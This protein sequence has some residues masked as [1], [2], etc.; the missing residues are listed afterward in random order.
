MPVTGDAIVEVAVDAAELRAAPSAEGAVLETLSQ[1]DELYLGAASETVGETV[2]WPATNPEAGARGYIEETELAF[3]DFL[4][5]PTPVS[6]ED[7]VAAALEQ[8]VPIA[9]A[10]S[11]DGTTA[12]FV[13]EVRDAGALFSE[14]PYVSQI[15]LRDDDLRGTA[16]GGILTIVGAAL[17]PGDLPNLG[18]VVMVSGVAQ[19][20]HD[21]ASAGWVLPPV[22]EK[23]YLDR[24]SIPVLVSDFDSD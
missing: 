24:E 7:V 23:P 21:Y 19:M 14:L 4:P 5:T 2:W 16:A 18:D 1:G 8:C 3:V 6:D 11:Y 22:I 10:T 9:E 12:C 17:E 15:V 20:D 13:G